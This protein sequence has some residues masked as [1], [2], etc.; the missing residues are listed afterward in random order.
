MTTPEYDQD[1]LVLATAARLLDGDASHV[2]VP[3]AVEGL[4]E[5][6]VIESVRRLDRASPPYWT[7]MPGSWGTTNIYGLSGLT[8]RGQRE[9]RIWPRTED[10]YAAR[11]L[12]LLEEVAAEV[13]EEQRGPLRKTLGYLVT[14]G[15]AVLTGVAA[16]L[17]TGGHIS[18]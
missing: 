4:T 7:A 10:A 1:M 15:R 12:Q 17:I 2:R 8:E 11:M 16:S 9:G 13:P 5:Q 3:F 14:D 18:G 6:Q